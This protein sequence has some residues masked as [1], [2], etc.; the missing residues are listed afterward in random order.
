MLTYV[1]QLELKRRLNAGDGDCL[2]VDAD[3]SNET[4]T[5]IKGA[6]EEFKK[7]V[8]G[9]IISGCYKNKDFVN[10]QP[11]AKMISACNEYMKTR[12]TTLGF[13]R[14]VCFVAFKSR[15]VDDPGA[16]V[17]RSRPETGMAER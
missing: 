8:A 11:R 10:F 9:N 12:D 17:G 4:S 14:R 5:S 6:E 16:G 13:L 15:F 2:T 3:T 1:E 7:V